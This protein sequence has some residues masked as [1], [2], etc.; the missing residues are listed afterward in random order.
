MRNLLLT[1]ATLLAALAYPGAT[2]LAAEAPPGIGSLLDPALALLATAVSVAVGWVGKRLV[3]WLGLQAEERYRQVLLQALDKAAEYALNWALEQVGQKPPSR[4]EILQVGARYVEQ[5]VPTALRKL[6]I[7]TFT[8][9]DKIAAR[10]R[11]D[12]LDLRK[13]GDF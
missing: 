6:K 8:L 5:A 13:L 2:A 7:D 4:D 10:I 3:T 1:I 9:P 12:E 11:P